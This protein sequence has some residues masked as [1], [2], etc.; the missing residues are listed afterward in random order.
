MYNELWLVSQRWWVG[1]Y[2]K[3]DWSHFHPLTDSLVVWLVCGVVAVGSAEAAVQLQVMQSRL[4]H[5][6]ADIY[7]AASYA[8]KVPFFSV[9]FSGSSD[10]LVGY[11]RCVND[12]EGSTEY[13]WVS[14]HLIL[15]QNSIKIHGQDYKLWTTTLCKRR[16]ICLKHKVT[17]SKRAYQAGI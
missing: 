17:K 16:N 1:L 6:I 5:K 2:C 7:V 13:R 12:R 3:S 11:T 14:M 9:H 8:M 15:V 4:R 10:D